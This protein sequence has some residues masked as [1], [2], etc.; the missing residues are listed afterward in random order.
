[1]REEIAPHPYPS[2]QK[3]RGKNIY[4][5]GAD[6]A[7]RF[8]SGAGKCAKNWGKYREMLRFVT[9]AGMFEIRTPFFTL[10]PCIRM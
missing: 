2:P 1:M 4:P 7:D 10:Y 3:E 6:S 5:C 9:F 8:A